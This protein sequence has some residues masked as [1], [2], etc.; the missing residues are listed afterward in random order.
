[1]LNGQAQERSGQHPLSRL[2]VAGQ[3][4]RQQAG[5]TRWQRRHGRDAPRLLDQGL[6]D[7]M[8]QARQFQLGKQ[9]GQCVVASQPAGNWC[10][11]KLAQPRCIAITLHS[12]PALHFP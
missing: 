6:Q 3:A 11:G 4:G 5:R 2:W 12:P 1:M 7:E 10:K 8:G 9:R